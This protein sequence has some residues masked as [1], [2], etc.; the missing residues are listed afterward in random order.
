MR[1]KL[2]APN[3][4]NSNPTLYP[5][6][7]IK[8]NTGAGNGTPVNEFIYG[9][10]HEMKDKLARLYGIE[11]NG[12]PDNETNGYQTIESLRALASKNDF[13]IDLTLSSGIVSAAIKLGFMLEKESVLCL[14]GF[15][16]STETQIKGIDNVTYSLN[17]IGSFKS[18][19]YVRLIKTSTG[20]TLI[21]EVD[22]VNLDL[23][24]SEFNFLKK[25]S[26]TQENAGTIDTAAT[27]PLTNKT[28][29]ERRVN[30]VD[31]S[32]YLATQ[33]RN[34]LLSKEDKVI[35]DNI[36]ANPIKNI[37]WFSGFNPG[38]GTI[39]QNLPVSGNISNAKIVDVLSGM[40][41]VECT[42]SNAMTGTNYEVQTSIES[43]GTFN[44][45]TPVYPCL[46]KV[47]SNNT[48]QIAMREPISTTHNLKI[49]VRTIQ[50]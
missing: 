32:S 42:L 6:G 36:A 48:I 21:R 49:H 47:I 2:L 30:G 38:S 9:D 35:I 27:T 4:D 3:I 7:R 39:N 14:A 33:L 25:A 28:V 18:G 29:F 34:G 23:A 11:P 10:I 37:G 44:N 41:V 26:Q 22:A 15:N 1:K 40:T 46:F 50:L 20:I 43:L 45:D 31:S 5:W 19:E 13:I 17:L 16:F 8:D 24:V 12:L